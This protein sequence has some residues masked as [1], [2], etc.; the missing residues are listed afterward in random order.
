MPEINAIVAGY[1]VDVLWRDH[2]LI[3]ELDGQEFHEF[4]FESD[5][6]KDATLVTAGYRVVRVTWTRL[7]EQAARE[8]GRFRTL[9]A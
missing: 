9:L 8:A 3:A 2:R 4:T 7:T 1:E 6:E 5:R